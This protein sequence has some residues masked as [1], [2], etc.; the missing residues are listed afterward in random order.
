MYPTRRSI[1]ARS[2]AGRKTDWS[3]LKPSTIAARRCPRPGAHVLDD[4]RLD[5]LL[6]QV[7]GEHG[8]LPGG[9]EPIGLPA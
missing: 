3:T 9:L 6:G 1:P 5:L 4:F 7:Q 2:P 8:F